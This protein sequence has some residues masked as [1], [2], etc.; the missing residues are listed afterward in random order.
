MRVG[1]ALLFVA[2][3]GVAGRWLP[4]R[5]TG[6]NDFVEYAAA[7]RV[8]LAGGNPYDP[9]RL[10]PHQTAAGWPHPMAQMMWNPPWVF[11]LVLPAG[12]PAAGPAFALWAAVQFAAVV[13]AA[14][15]AWRL[16]GG[17][18]A[19]TP[20]VVLL[21][22]V[23]PP[24]FFLVCLGQ[25]SGFALAG[26]VGFLA[27]LRAGRPAAAGIALALTAVKPHLLLPFAALLAAVAATHRPTRRAV[28]VGSGVLVAAAVFPMLW[29]P[30]V[31]PDW[32]AATRTPADEFHLSP[33]DWDPPILAAELSK[34]FGNSLAV[35]FVPS[36]AATALL[37]VHWWRR[38][39]A[40]NWERE[41]PAVVLVCLLTTGYGAWG[42]DLVLLLLPCAQAAA[43]VAA[44]GRARLVLWAVLVYLAGCAA[45]YMALLP[46]LWW[47]PAVA[48]GSVALALLARPG[49]AA[50]P[51]AAR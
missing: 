19:W 28:L 11:P 39:H 18:R 24:A 10:L 26:L 20:L 42:F 50:R 33:A 8:L 17:P 48:A 12:M 15:A 36:A 13:W 9:Q 40:W 1:L 21:A 23:F 22:A 27:G 37:L 16:Y 25:I 29:N 30:H 34:A 6:E 46:V 47:T 35:Q 32:L 7:A 3:A 41:L 38:R 4:P 49:Q 5:W 45:V 51:A 43:W 31:W 2:A 14:A 44:D